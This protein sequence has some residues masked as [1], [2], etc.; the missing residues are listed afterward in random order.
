MRN[1][2]AENEKMRFW[3]LFETIQEGMLFRCWVFI[4][5]LDIPFSLRYSVLLLFI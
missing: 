4:L 3:G 2:A 5:A 1:F